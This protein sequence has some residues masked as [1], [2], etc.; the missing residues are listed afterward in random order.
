MWYPQGALGGR[1]GN[2]GAFMGKRSA[3][4]AV[5]YNGLDGACAAAMVLLNHP[6]AGLVA[7]SAARIGKSFAELAGGA[8]RPW[9]STYAA[10]ECTATGRRCPGLLWR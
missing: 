2:G 10:S 3:V 4:V 9:E 1:T 8:R 7:T 5:T 6:T